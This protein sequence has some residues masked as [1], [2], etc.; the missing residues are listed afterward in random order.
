MIH[1]HDRGFGEQ[2]LCILTLR[3]SGPCSLTV[4]IYTLNTACL[5]AEN[6]SLLIIQSSRH[7]SWKQG[8]SLR[9]FLVKSLPNEFTVG[10]H[11]PSFCFIVPYFNIAPSWC[12]C[13]RY[14]L[15]NELSWCSPSLGATTAPYSSL[16]PTHKEL[17]PHRRPKPTVARPAT[18][19]PGLAQYHSLVALAEDSY[20]GLDY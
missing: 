16:S 4:Y 6:L 2:P 5:S 11:H 18:H 13:R 20:I 15:S 8:S 7:I 9:S 1:A 12:L 3:F 10:R 19:L 17:L 14:L